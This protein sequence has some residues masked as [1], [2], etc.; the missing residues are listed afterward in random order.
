MGW[1]VKQLK[2]NTNKSLSDQRHFKRSEHWHI[3]QGSIKINLEWS[4]GDEYLWFGKVGD[5]LDIPSLTWHK[6]INT[7]QKSAIIIEVWLGNEL[8]ED[9]I[10]RR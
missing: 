1:Q 2:L 7:G 4:N 8:S 5:S 6:A 10:E 3:V 9:D